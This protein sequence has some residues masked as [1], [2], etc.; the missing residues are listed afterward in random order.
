M[1]ARGQAGSTGAWATAMATVC[2][3]GAALTGVSGTFIDGRR[4]VSRPKLSAMAV[5]IGPRISGVRAKN[6]SKSALSHSV[7]MTRATP[8]LRW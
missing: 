5:I 6:A 8:P 3:A 2:M 7:L 4:V 1:T